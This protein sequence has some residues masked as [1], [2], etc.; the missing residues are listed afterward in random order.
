LLR[1][2]LKF[3]PRAT[4]VVL[5]GNFEEDRVSNKWWR[6]GQEIVNTML[7][8]TFDGLGQGMVV[9]APIPTKE[10][11]GTSASRR[12]QDRAVVDTMKRNL[13]ITPQ[14]CFSLSKRPQN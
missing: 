2:T 1:L 7:A 3:G 9:L 6:K 14:P 13:S 4:V 11:D 12:P 5:L 10:S 8:S